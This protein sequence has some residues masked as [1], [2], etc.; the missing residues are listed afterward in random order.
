MFVKVGTVF[1]GIIGEVWLTNV[2][3]GIVDDIVLDESDCG[4]WIADSG[5]IVGGICDRI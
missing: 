4:M 5:V 1:N 2:E 3:D